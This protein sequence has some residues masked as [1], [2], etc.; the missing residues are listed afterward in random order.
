[1]KHRFFEVCELVCSCLQITTVL[2]NLLERSDLI[3]MVAADHRWE[4][5]AANSA[6]RYK[7]RAP[8][9]IAPRQ[10]DTRMLKSLHPL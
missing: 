1:M 3:V 6:K 9:G 8:P 4:R 2:I 10:L 5:A 7:G